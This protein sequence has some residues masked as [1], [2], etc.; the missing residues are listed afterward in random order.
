M[1]GVPEFVWW[2]I[3]F[4]GLVL[5]IGAVLWLFSLRPE[6]I[7]W[8][9]QFDKAHEEQK[10]KRRDLVNL[11]RLL[12]NKDLGE[13]YLSLRQR[14]QRQADDGF[15]ILD[16]V[17]RKL[18]SANPE[19]IRSLPTWSFG[20]V[21]PIFY[22]LGQRLLV[23][24]QLD[25]A[26]RQLELVE[27]SL[28]AV[29]SVLNEVPRQGRE[30]LRQVQQMRK[31]VLNLQQQALGLNGVGALTKML[32]QLASALSSLD[33]ANSFLQGTG[34]DDQQSVVRAFAEL[35]Q[36]Q[37][38][39][40]DAEA[41]L[42]SFRKQREKF[43]PKLE[44]AQRL[45]AEMD[46]VLKDEETHYACP[47]FR[48]EWM[49]I[50]HA[51][52]GLWTAFEAGR[53]EQVEAGLTQ[54]Q[55]ICKDWQ[56]RLKR[57]QQDRERLERLYAKTDEQLT[58]LR[59]WLQQLPATYQMDVSQANV[60][61]LEE[62][63]L[64]VMQ[65]LRS[66]RAED[67]R[68]F[69]EFKLEKVQQAQMQFQQFLQRYQ[70]LLS[71]GNPA[72][73]DALNQRA[74]R[75]LKGLGER[76]EQYRSRGDWNSL[77]EAFESLQSA[78]TLSQTN[79]MT[80][81][82]SR[83]EETILVW[84]RLQEAMQAL[85]RRCDAAEK[86]LG[87]VKSDLER[88]KKVL[89]SSVFKQCDEVIRNGLPEQRTQAQH[90]VNQARHLRERIDK[91]NEDF[92][93]VA[94]MAEKLLDEAQRLIKTYQADL[95]KN[96][97]LLSKLKGDLSEVRAQANSLHQ[98]ESLYFPQQEKMEKQIVRW[99]A[100]VE[101]VTPNSLSEMASVVQNGQALY[102]E[103][104]AIFDVMQTEI[105]K[106]EEMIGQV[107][108]ALRQAEVALQEARSEWQSAPG[109]QSNLEGVNWFVSD[110]MMLQQ[111]RESLGRV[112]HPFRKQL[113]DAVLDDLRQ[114]LV[115]CQTVEK[116]AKQIVDEIRR[117][118]KPTMGS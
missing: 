4:V 57:L 81:V 72:H 97:E 85:T 23:A 75:I 103:T 114:T 49:E 24:W 115:S 90:L 107:K 66:D 89:D 70:R 64:R 95:S 74:E 10:S 54:Q 106:V 56:E 16:S 35:Q 19:K 12:P 28:Q 5:T 86:V 63:L 101:H 46:E 26:N 87:Q 69:Q 9:Q 51:L 108:N 96:Q 13:P 65:T 18:E 21:L 40:K 31:D 32:D 37:E 92:G 17:T 36:A 60:Q 34:S 71:E 91:P 116:H 109:F 98:H 100:E 99:L 53:F 44:Q 7:I 29:Q 30:V 73:V 15:R 27:K 38:K 33:K 43:A 11:A 20:F 117:K 58:D 22:E 3:A 25:R 47:T 113:A 52:K 105:K 62:Q 45:L 102:R 110:E 41:T 82:E 50:E 111:A 61:L 55:K 112:L 104:K 80:V 59:D 6:E 14:G 93:Q 88:A 79:G 1:N 67:Y 42:E 94:G 8:K 77:Q 68:K 78:W 83:L 39:V 48:Q 118:S 2:L 76:H 84:Q